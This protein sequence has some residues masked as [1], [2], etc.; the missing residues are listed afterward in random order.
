MLFPGGSKFTFISINEYI[1]KYTSQI[2]QWWAK[3]RSILQ[4][5]VKNMEKIALCPCFYLGV[6]FLDQLWENQF[7]D[8]L[9]WMFFLFKGLGV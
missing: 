1:L 6:A 8:V 5:K 9:E 2:Y 7:C 3:L 4:Q